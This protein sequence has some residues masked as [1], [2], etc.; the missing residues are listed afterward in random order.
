M[1]EFDRFN[2]WSHGP[3]YLGRALALL[4]SLWACVPWRAPLVA[5]AGRGRASLRA[6]GGRPE[7]GVGWRVLP[8]RCS[9]L[10]R[11]GREDAV[12]AAAG[13]EAAAAAVCEWV[14]CFAG[15]G[16]ERRANE[17]RGG[18]GGLLLAV[19][20]DDAVWAGA[21]LAGQ[22]GVFISPQATSGECK[23]AISCSA[24]LVDM[25][26]PSRPRRHR[27][28][29]CL[30]HHRILPCY[31]LICPV[32][33]SCYPLICPVILSCYYLICPVILSCYPLICPVIA[34]EVVLDLSALAYRLLASPLIRAQSLPP[35]GVTSNQSSESTASWRHL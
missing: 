28:P 31:P 21:V 35:L 15:R 17:W 7:H 8:S 5:V 12:A 13:G 10:M 11:G 32:I 19:V 3:A 34:V 23:M 18:R 25:V 33:L 9:R 6:G 20:T 4:S 30:H 29:R 1:W 24:P 27:L 2:E 22:E 16:D 14:D 26:S